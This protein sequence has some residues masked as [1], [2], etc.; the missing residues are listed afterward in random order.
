M[1][2]TA[3]N[4]DINTRLSVLYK[5]LQD[6][7]LAAYVEAFKDPDPPQRINE[8]GIVDEACYDADNGILFVAKET[9]GWRNEDYA[10]GILFRTWLQDMAKHGLSGHA[11]QHPIMWYNIGRWASFL[12]DPSQDV[13]KL[14]CEK[15]VEKVGRAA[16]TN[17]NEVRGGS[18]SADSYWSLA[19]ASITGKLLK[20]ELDI[21]QPKVIVCCGTYN[22]FLYHVPDFDGPVIRMPHPGARMRTKAML[23]QLA[24]QLPG[25]SDYRL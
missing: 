22:E 16:F 24:A 14:A 20:K 12:D 11:K 19:Y 6:S 9:N 1:I 3:R 18:R 10:A 15:T 17:M 8:F 13:E 21:I 4:R 25:E 5:E 2:G 7:C 23:E